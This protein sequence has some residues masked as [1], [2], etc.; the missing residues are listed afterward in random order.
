MSAGTTQLETEIQTHG[1]AL[2]D[3][4]DALRLSLDDQDHLKTSVA[5]LK[6]AAKGHVELVTALKHANDFAQQQACIPQDIVRKLSS[7]IE[8]FQQRITEITGKC[9]EQKA[10]DLKVQK[11]TQG[12]RRD[13]EKE[14]GTSTALQE[15]LESQTQKLTKKEEEVKELKVKRAE[16]EESLK[17]TQNSISKVRADNEEKDK[18]VITTFYGSNVTLTNFYLDS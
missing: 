1:S 6:V 11:E 8:D 5:E 13:Y 7:Q 3:S 14:K 4:L 15:A 18:E 17:H 10:K 16:I 12:L 2:K 9:D